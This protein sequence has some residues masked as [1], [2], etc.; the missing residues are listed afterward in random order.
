MLHMVLRSPQRYWAEVRTEIFIKVCWRDREKVKEIPSTVSLSKMLVMAGPGFRARNSSQ[1]GRSPVI[2][3]ADT[4]PPRKTD[5]AAGGGNG[6][7]SDMSPG[8]LH[9][10]LHVPC[11]PTDFCLPLWSHPAIPSGVLA[12]G[13]CPGLTLVHA[14]WCP[15]LLWMLLLLMGMYVLLIFQDVWHVVSCSEKPC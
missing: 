6:G 10:W 2:T 11:Q 15:V 7:Q 14:V 12:A 8:Y 13:P 5:S 9:G 1:D 3:W 4:H